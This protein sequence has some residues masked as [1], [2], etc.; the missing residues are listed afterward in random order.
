MSP[1]LPY[2]LRLAETS[3]SPRRKRGQVTAASTK[4]TLQNRHAGEVETGPRRRYQVQPAHQ[5]PTL[6]N[7]PGRAFDTLSPSST[8]SPSFLCTHP[9][10]RV[11]VREI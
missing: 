9:P 8:L 4:P 6:Q 10:E 1:Y 3:G 7:Q 2:T 5:E 11:K